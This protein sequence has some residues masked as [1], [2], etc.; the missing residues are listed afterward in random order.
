MW[1]EKKARL[2]GVIWSYLQVGSVLPK[3]LWADNSLTYSKE[4]TTVSSQYAS[5]KF[6][7]VLNCLYHDKG[8]FFV[9]V[10]FFTSDKDLQLDIITSIFSGCKH[11]K[12]LNWLMYKFAFL[13]LLI[14]TTF[15]AELIEWYY[16]RLTLCY[17]SIWALQ[18]HN[19]YL[20]Q[21]NWNKSCNSFN[22][23]KF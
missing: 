7:P 1:N 13:L 6:I 16:L 17:C 19:T 9:F 11:A 10:F 20:F 15:S 4:V 18:Y 8:V 12:L 2:V 3:Q 14:A 21:Q 5:E 23:T 22:P